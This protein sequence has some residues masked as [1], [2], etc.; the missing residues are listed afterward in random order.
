MTNTP[1]PA[2]ATTR[3]AAID[4]GTNSVLLAIADRLDN[5][6]VPHLERA[7]IT[8]LGQGVDRSRRLA[9]DAIERTLA[10]LTEYARDLQAAGSPPLRVVGTSAMRDAAGGAEFVAR[11]AEIL[12]VAPEV[13]SGSEEAELTYTG[14]L[15]G[16]SGVGRAGGSSQG[17]SVV[18]FDI[19]GGSTEVIIA[20]GADQKFS[21]SLDIG[22][23]RLTERHVNSDPPS[24]TD[25][26]RLRGDIRNALG[27][28]PT[29]PPDALLVGVAGTLTTLCAVSLDLVPYDAARVHG[30]TLSL[31]RLHEVT[32][33]LSQLSVEQRRQL[34]SLEPKR[35]DVIVAGAVIACEVMA[36]S[37][38][39]RLTIS[40]RGVRWGI[41]ERLLAS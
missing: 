18:V 6:L 29:A 14:A 41:L 8:R 13:I 35:A 19:G 11:A 4:I 9:K 40:D 3:A 32:A 27:S 31:G 17:S 26:D 36:W 33:M 28:L 10:C 7:T 38:A 34:P 12:G 20:G 24:P 39:Q 1:E 16:L 21:V 23:V 5:Q 2:T 37:Q 25:L 30:A 22:A 15:S